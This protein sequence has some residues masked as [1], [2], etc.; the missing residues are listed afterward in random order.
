MKKFLER[1]FPRRS[2]ARIFLGV[3]KNHGLI[4]AIVC[5]VGS[6]VATFKLT[7][8][9][10]RIVCVVRPGVKVKITKGR[11]ASVQM[12]G[13]LI[14]NPHLMLSGSSALVLGSNSQFSVLGDFEI[15]QNVAISLSQGATM[16]IGGQFDSSGA[17]ITADTKVMVERSLSIGKDAII[18]WGC[19]ITDSDWH[20][21]SGRERCA[22]VSIGDDVWISHE[23]SILKGADIPK[24]CIVGARSVVGYAK[25]PENSFIAGAPAAVK[26]QGVSWER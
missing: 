18:A 23:V 5:I 25:Y 4:A 12:Q 22:P 26:R 14:F 6:I 7:G 20:N 24:G 21:I 8:S 19:T 15:G 17:G 16:T 13:R 10:R 3:A 1:L 2:T 11:G 9:I